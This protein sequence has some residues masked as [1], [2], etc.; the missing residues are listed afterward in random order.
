MAASPKTQP[1]SQY[2]DEAGTFLSIMDEM[3][4]QIRLD[5]SVESLQRLDQFISEHFEPIGEKNVGETLPTGIGCYLG[6]VIVRNLGGY[7]NKEGKPEINGLGQIDAVFPIE[8][9]LRRFEGGKQE[10]LAWY[11]HSLVKQAYEAG[12][13]PPTPQHA[14]SVQRRSGNNA[15]GGLFGLL[16]GI[17]G[18]K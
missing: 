17:F 6:E 7:W 16:K 18:K 8:K 13:Q 5:Y 12:H 4:P 11:Y 15:G 3:A 14:P 10:A 1:A 2:R 9:A